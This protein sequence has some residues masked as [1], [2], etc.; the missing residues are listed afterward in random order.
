M[1]GCS[2]AGGEG[3]KGCG[4]AAESGLPHRGQTGGYPRLAAGPANHQAQERVLQ[5]NSHTFQNWPRK[6]LAITI[7][8]MVGT[9]L[10]LTS[11][12]LHRSF[13]A[14]ACFSGNFDLDIIGIKE[15]NNLNI[16]L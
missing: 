3:G 8:L 16:L 7:A 11:T 13:A 12:G 2:P 9:A 5:C 6:L 14:L 1:P 10:I 4:A 15:K